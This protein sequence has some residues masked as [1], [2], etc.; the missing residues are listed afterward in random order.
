MKC[1]TIECK[2][3]FINSI[4]TNIRKVEGLSRLARIPIGE[5]QKDWGVVPDLSKF[6][7]IVLDSCGK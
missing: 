4:V 6:A 7:D 3:Y 1:Y 5:Y 2:Q